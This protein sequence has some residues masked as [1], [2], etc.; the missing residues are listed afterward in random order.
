ME[1]V[2][3]SSSLSSSLSL[4][5]VCARVGGAGWIE[6]RMPQCLCQR[7]L[8]RSRARSH[9]MTSEASLISLYGVMVGVE[10]QARVR[11]DWLDARPTEET[12]VNQCN[13]RTRV[14]ATDSRLS[15]EHILTTHRLFP[16]PL[17]SALTLFLPPYPT[18]PSLLPQAIPCLVQTPSVRPFCRAH[19]M[20]SETLPRR[21]T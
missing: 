8:S 4:P 6:R 16:P 12:L 21:R 14:T 17:S 13:R 2:D 10:V 11:K 7:C 20:S 15:E 9:S 19:G 1:S 3:Y 5:S 18:G